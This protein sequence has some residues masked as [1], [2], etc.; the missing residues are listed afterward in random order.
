[1][2]G[3]WP[4]VAL[5]SARSSLAAVHYYSLELSLLTFQVRLLIKKFFYGLE[6]HLLLP[7]LVLQFLFEPVF[8]VLKLSHHFLLF[9]QTPPC[10]QLLFE[11][12][13]Y[14]FLRLQRFICA[15]LQVLH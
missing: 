6:V 14:S 5:S 4:S 9:L 12:L 1:M 13:N 7:Q 15:F 10:A 2:P 3:R 11:Q 8:L